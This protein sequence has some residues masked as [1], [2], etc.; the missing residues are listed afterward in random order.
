[1]KKLFAIAFSFTL[2][3]ACKPIKK[4]EL[5]VTGDPGRISYTKEVAATSPREQNYDNLMKEIFVISPASKI[6]LEDKYNGN[7]QVVG[8]SPYL[9]KGGERK[10]SYMLTCNFTNAKA[11]IIINGIHILHYPL[12]KIYFNDKRHNVKK[13]NSSYEDINKKVLAIQADLAGKVK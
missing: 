6:V 1:M 7:F 13:L 4:V 8:Y 9:Y 10:F 2:L 12:E 11:E 3:F 5:P